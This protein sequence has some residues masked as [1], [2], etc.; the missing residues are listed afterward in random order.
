M[1]LSKTQSNLAAVFLQFINY[2]KKEN[3]KMARNLGLDDLKDM[4]IGDEVVIPDHSD[5]SGYRNYSKSIA[6]TVGFLLGISDESLM[7]RL[8][9]P[10]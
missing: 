10:E 8:E 6:L 5:K 9:F 7:K 2:F 3:N 4:V 1:L